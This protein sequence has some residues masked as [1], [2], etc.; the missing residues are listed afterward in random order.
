MMFTPYLRVVPMHAVIVAVDKLGGFAG[1]VFL[2]LRAGVDIGMVLIQRHYLD[3]RRRAIA[4]NEA[5]R[6]VRQ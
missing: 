5:K 1:F 3:E 4:I 6:K 2:P